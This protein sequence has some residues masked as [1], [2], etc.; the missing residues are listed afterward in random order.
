MHYFSYLGRPLALNLL[1]NNQLNSSL[2]QIIDSQVSRWHTSNNSSYITTCV[3]TSNFDHQFSINFPLNRLDVIGKKS[4]CKSLRR[5]TVSNVA[6]ASSKRWNTLWTRCL[7][8]LTTNQKLP[9]SPMKLMK[10]NKSPSV[11]H[12]KVILEPSS[13]IMWAF[14]KRKQYFRTYFDPWTNVEIYL[15]KVKSFMLVE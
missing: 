10:N 7:E 8:L 5:L 11:T 3:S 13:L 2:Q 15:Q 12:W 1:V 4:Q 14:L 6:R 9:I